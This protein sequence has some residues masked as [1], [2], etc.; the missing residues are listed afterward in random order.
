MPWP[1]TK[2]EK[3]SLVLIYKNLSLKTLFDG[4]IHAKKMLQIT[5]PDLI[6]YFSHAPQRFLCNLSADCSKRWLQIG[7]FQISVMVFL[8][9]FFDVFTRSGYYKW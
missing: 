4:W 6:D 7:S 3:F 8:Y 9:N 5:E 1:A 2:V